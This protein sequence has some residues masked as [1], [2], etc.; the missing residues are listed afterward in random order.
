[1]GNNGVTKA[2]LA[3]NALFL[4]SSR[5]FGEGPFGFQTVLH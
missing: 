5:Y 1:M 4:P 3:W 2:V